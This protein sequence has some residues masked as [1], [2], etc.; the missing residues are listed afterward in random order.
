MKV[1]IVGMAD[2]VH[3]GR[4]VSQF[5]EDEYLFELVSS[6]PHRRLNHF[7]EDRLT[8]KTNLQMMRISRHFSLVLWLVDRVFADLC[9]GALIAHRIRKFNPE[10]VHVH[11]LQNAGYATLRAYQ[12]LKGKKPPLIVTNYGSELV[13][14]S[15]YRSHRSRLKAL[16]SIAQ[17]FSAECE[18]DYNLAR[19]LVPDLSYLPLMPVAGGFKFKIQEEQRRNIIAVKGYQNRWGKALK[20]LEALSEISAELSDLEVVVYGCNRSVVRKAK[21][22][23]RKGLLNIRTFSKMEMSHDEVLRLFSHSIAYIGHSLSDGISTAM[24]EAMAMGAIPIQTNTSCATDWIEDGRSGYIIE[25]NDSTSIKS[26]V[27][28]I[29]NNKDLV[30]KMRATNYVTIKKRYDSDML[31]ETALGYYTRF[32]K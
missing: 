1:L 10:V 13:W 8:K 29:L 21:A 14:F 3:L 16:L 31:T 7:I 15:K 18:R 22:Y 4:W 6:S 30:E 12:L 27:L 17:F 19:E 2:S 20:V 24:L 9:R 5:P 23:S 28:E 26:A 11:E 25:P 32:R